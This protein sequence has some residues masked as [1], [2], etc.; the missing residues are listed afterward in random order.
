MPIWSDRDQRLYWIDVRA[1]ALYAYDP[2]NGDV[3][4]HTMRENIGSFCEREAGGM[5][6]A[7]KSGLYLYDTQ[8]RAT[9]LWFDPEPTLPNN[10]LN[11]G[12]CDRQGRFWVGSM[13]D[14]DRLPTGTLY[15]IEQKGKCRSFVN[16]ITIPNSLAFSPD[17]S[18]MYFADTPTKKI[19]VYDFD[20]DDG[21][22]S[23]PRV[24]RD[25][26][27]HP[28]RPDGSTVDVDGCL[29][30]AEVHASRVVRYTP[31]GEIDQ[32]IELPVSGV[33]S[34]AF[35]G[36][37][38]DTLYITTARQGLTSEQLGN[39]PLA[40]ALFAALTGTTGVAETLLRG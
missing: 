24:F 31:R 39:Q 10:R 20:P 5:L 17:G 8:S 12:K 28:G 19:M 14:G 27:D 11:D 23:N 25:M 15:S 29:W 1:P 7:M 32:I 34:C 38:L 22:P 13:N 4:T 2:A 18:L 30:N 37:R 33:T 40:G 36:P 35:G 21:V 16:G 3:Q 26:H 9:E 6:L